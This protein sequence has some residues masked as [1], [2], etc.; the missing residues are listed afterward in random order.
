[1]KPT[2]CF[3]R[4]FLILV[5]VAAF[6]ALAHADSSLDPTIVIRDPA[7]PSGGCMQVGTHF[8]FGVP[9]T[10]QG[11]L[12]FTNVSGVN[13][14]NLQLT[15][16]GVSAN[17]IGC[18][19]TAFANCTVSTINGL[20]TIFLSGINQNFMGIT[21]GENFSIVFGCVN[22]AC[23]PGGLDFTA[24]ANVPEPGTVA[25][26]LTGL[27]GIVTRRRQLKRRKA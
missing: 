15:E 10:G 20:T 26:V 6:G 18:S 14:T 1:M 2:S 3:S 27:G 9:S 12:F 21:A 5:V 24:T 19:S 23:W 16:S 7:C 22:D 13:W 4:V 11:T 25:L 8:T 17:V